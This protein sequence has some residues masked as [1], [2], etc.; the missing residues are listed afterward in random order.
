M[1]TEQPLCCLKQA[2]KK[3]CH[4]QLYVLIKMTHIKYVKFDSVFPFSKYYR[5]LEAWRLL[6]KVCY[7][8]PQLKMLFP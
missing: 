7:G 3:I 6:L 1:A 8:L 2:V 4:G 5:I